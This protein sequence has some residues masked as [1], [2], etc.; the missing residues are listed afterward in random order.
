MAFLAEVDANFE[1]FTRSW[2][3]ERD[4]TQTALD[5]SSDV[6]KNSYRRLTSL[7]AWRSMLLEQRL[8]A[9]SL[10]F[11]LEAQNDVLVSHTLAQVGSW[12]SALQALRSCLENVAV[13]L[14]YKDHPVELRLWQD[15]RHRIGFSAG[16][17]YLRQHPDL[18]GVPATISGLDTLEK[19]Y[20]VLSR[21]VHASAANFRMTADAAT[22]ILCSSSAV[23]LGKWRTRESECVSSLNLL[24]T[25]LYRLDLQGARLP[26]LRQAISLA[27]PAG[28][29]PE[30]K[31]RLK[32]AL[33]KA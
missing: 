23:S 21:A 18:K 6:F 5:A 7:Q 16:V 25:S 12:R 22:T 33:A 11:F 31:A 28:R 15:G 3:A 14:Y 24:L 30:V 1:R 9:A 27:V 32:V 26:G 10:A 4:R 19:E 13:C 20:G 29:Y 8:A 2:R 17:G